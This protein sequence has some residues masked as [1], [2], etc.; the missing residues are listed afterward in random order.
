MIY[1]FVDS[2][3]TLQRVQKGETLHTYL[4][5]QRVFQLQKEGT[6]VWMRWCP[7]HVGIEGNEPADELA[8]LGLE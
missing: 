5:W 2:Q 6:K 4:I 1:I 3:A 8:K 7:S